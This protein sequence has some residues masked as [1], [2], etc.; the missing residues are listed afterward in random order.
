MISLVMSFRTCHRWQFR[1]NAAW[2]WSDRFTTLDH[3]NYLV[4][5]TAEVTIGSKWVVPPTVSAAEQ[6]KKNV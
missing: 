5:F 3:F 4:G 2:G 6:K 1:S